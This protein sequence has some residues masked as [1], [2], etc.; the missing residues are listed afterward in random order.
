MAL[1]ACDGVPMPSGALESA[2]GLL[3][4]PADPTRSDIVEAIKDC[5]AEGFCS[6]V[7]DTFSQEVTWTLSGKGVHKARELR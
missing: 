5:E 3:A 7:T 4:R 2:V 6:G 1:A